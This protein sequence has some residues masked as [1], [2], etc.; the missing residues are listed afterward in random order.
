MK[1]DQIKMCLK[2]TLGAYDSS[3]YKKTI[4]IK[5]DRGYFI[6]YINVPTRECMFKMCN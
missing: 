3:E 5:I 4:G 6:I 1:N 2:K